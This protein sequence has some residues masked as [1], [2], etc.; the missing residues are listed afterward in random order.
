MRMGRNPRV[1]SEPADFPPERI[2]ERA[3]SRLVAPPSWRTRPFAHWCCHRSLSAQ[4]VLH[5]AAGAAGTAV[6][7]AVAWFVLRS[8]G[9]K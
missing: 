8:L 7:L 3:L 9:A 6:G 4:L 5:A 2:V 1:V